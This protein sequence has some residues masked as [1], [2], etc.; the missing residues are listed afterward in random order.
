MQKKISL[1]QT[2]IRKTRCSYTKEFKVSVVS[3]C[4]ADGNSIAQV[5]LEHQIY[6]NLIYK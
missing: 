3:E 6:A 2:T 4:Q 1:S 5:A